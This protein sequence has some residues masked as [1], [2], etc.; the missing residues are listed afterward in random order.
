MHHWDMLLPELTVMNGS[1]GR[2]I[3]TQSLP[4]ETLHEQQ[5]SFPVT[6]LDSSASH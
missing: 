2:T 3:N 1:L 6:T 5:H 4:D